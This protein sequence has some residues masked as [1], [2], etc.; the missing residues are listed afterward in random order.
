MKATP[1][2]FA[3]ALATAPLGA[4]AAEPAPARGWRT[5][6]GVS[7]LALGAGGLG[8]GLAGVLVA[9]DVQARVNAYTLPSADDQ[10]QTL[11]VLR[12]QRDTFTTLAAVGF[13]AG[14]LLLGGGVTLLALDGRPAAVALVP[15]GDGA[16]VS[17]ALRL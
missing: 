14:A 11:P 13:V 1:L 6:V 15:T 10:A 3:L 12:Q 9:N 4:R 16:F 17:L 5:G 2:L 7:L 8:L